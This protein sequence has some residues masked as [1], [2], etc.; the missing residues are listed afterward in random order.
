MIS[1]FWFW[2]QYLKTKT[3]NS[4]NFIKNPKMVEYENVISRILEILFEWH[5]SQNNSATLLIMCHIFVFQEILTPLD[6]LTWVCFFFNF[7]AQ[8]VE[9]VIEKQIHMHLNFID[10]KTKLF[11]DFRISVLSSIPENENWQIT[12]ILQK[13]HNTE[14]WECSFKNS[15]N[16][17]QVTSD[18]KLFSHIAN[19]VAGFG[20]LLKAFDPL[21]QKL[22]NLGYSCL[23]MSLY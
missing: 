1:G 21:G 10:Q 7:N 17:V 12:E 9:I 2:A 23:L 8:K 4:W 20:L 14:I 6:L 11:R 19:H 16:T 15:W 18:S 22:I 5:C 3:W 13:R